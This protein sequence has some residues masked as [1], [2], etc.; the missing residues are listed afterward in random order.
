MNTR[1]AEIFSP[2]IDTQTDLESLE[3]ETGQVW[4][5][6]YGDYEGV[7]LL[8]VKRERHPT[9]GNAIHICI[10]GPLFTKNGN[11]LMGIPHLPFTPEALRASDLEL[12][13]QVSRISD[14][15]VEMYED[16]QSDAEAGEAGLFS[17]T[18]TDILDSIF[19]RLSMF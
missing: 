7:T 13:G 3:F 15:W 19:S 11:E 2:R 14:D 1:L 17:L 5:I 8:V 4:R 12:V 18:V 10:R 6:G 9:L 16:W